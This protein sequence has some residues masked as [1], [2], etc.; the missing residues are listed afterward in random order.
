MAPR[1]SL[2]VP[3]R[4][5][6]ALLP[7]LLDSV[8]VARRRCAGG[9]DA[10]EVIVADNDSTDRTGAVARARGCRVVRVEP[11]VIAAVRNGG[12]RAA[13]GDLL[14]FVDA[15]FRVH[16]DTFGAIE[17]AMAGGRIVAGATGATVER[18]SPGIVA[19]YAMLLPLIVFARMNTGVVF[20]RR[21]D[22]EAV[23]G[24]DESLRFA[25]DVKFLWD[26]RRLGRARGQRLM[27]WTGSPAVA[28]ARKFDTH[29]EWHWL[30]LMARSV[31]WLLFARHRFHAFAREYWYDR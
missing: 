7:R 19:T 11:R 5:E 6:E 24:Y 4:N 8:D 25:E 2:V 18:W 29:G 10:V 31:P 3:A 20:C 15:D 12:A 22:F 9:L 30:A 14:A 26:L 23:G 28:S 13:R 17:R 27:A 21:P 1:I 16:P